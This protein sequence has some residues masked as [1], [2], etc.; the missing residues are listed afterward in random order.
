MYIC[1]CIWQ[2]K[3]QRRTQLRFKGADARHHLP[4]SPALA[5]S[6][7]TIW[8][9]GG[10]VFS[11]HPHREFAHTE[12]MCWNTAEDGWKDGDEWHPASCGKQL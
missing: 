4:C 2:E 5:S 11:L 9:Q 7:I 12:W 8:G 1:T 3:Q 10:L 6:A